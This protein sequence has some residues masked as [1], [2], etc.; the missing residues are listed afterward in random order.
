MSAKNTATLAFTTTLT[1][2]LDAW[3][4]TY[5]MSLEES[6]KDA[7]TYVATC[8]VEGLC[9]KVD[10][11]LISKVR[12][13]RQTEPLLTRTADHNW[14]PFVNGHGSRPWFIARKNSAGETEYHYGRTGNLV[15][16]DNFVTAKRG[17][18]RL[19]QER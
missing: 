13:T 8:I 10:E 11:G 3:A 9:P 17:A 19:N 6:L 15:R 4:L 1:V 5:G 14:S 2:D 18:D 7:K 12:T 16:Y